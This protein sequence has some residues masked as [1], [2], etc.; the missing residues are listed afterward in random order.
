MAETIKSIR[1]MINREDCPCSKTNCKRHGHCNECK[2]HH[3][4]SDRLRPCEK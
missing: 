1:T 2:A 4:D 3:A